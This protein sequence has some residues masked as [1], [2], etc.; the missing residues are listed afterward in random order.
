MARSRSLSTVP[1]SDTG[2]FWR[3]TAK[4]VAI[5]LRDVRLAGSDA[6][7][8]DAAVIA[9]A[10]SLNRQARAKLA[11]DRQRRRISRAAIEFRFG[12]AGL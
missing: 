8:A 6:S 2:L 9:A 1:S 5:G 10:A 3:P 11:D 12:P 7:P 4:A